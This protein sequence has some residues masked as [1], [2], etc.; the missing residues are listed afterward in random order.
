MLAYQERRILIVAPLGQDAQAVA[1]MLHGDGI[2]TEVCNHA[3]DCVERMEKGAG[4]LLLTEEALESL[5]TTE[6]LK[7]LGE[8]PPWSELPVIILTS[9]GESRLVGLLDLA[10]TAAR[11]VTLL[12]RPM[13]AATLLRSVQVALRSR[14]RQYQVRDLLLEQDRQHEKLRASEERFKLA[15]AAASA[16][17]WA[18][19]LRTGAAQWTPANYDLYGLSE[20]EVC[21][22]VE[23]WERNVHPEDLARVRQA[24][25]ETVE[26]VRPAYEVEYRVRHP[27]RGERWL[28]ALG[29]VERD[30]DGTPRRMAGIS[31]D[32]TARKEFQAELERLVRERTAKLQEVVGELEHFS[33]TITH[34]LKS[35]L[36][37]MRGFAELAGE[38]CGTS[39]AKPFLEKISRAAERMDA[40][41]RDALNYSRAV[42]QE[43]PLEDVDTGA[44]LRGILDSYPDF[45]PSKAHIRI[46]GPLPVVLGN[47]AGLTQ[48]FSNLLGNAVKFV[49][50]G[51]APE[52]RIWAETRNGWV[53]IWVADKGIGIA[54]SML[55]RVFDMFSRAS[56]A[57]E[58]T[59][60]GLA[61]VRK[62]VQRMGGRVGVD[63]QEGIGSRFWMEL[64]SGVS[65]AGQARGAV[66]GRE[67]TS[68]SVLYVE[69]EESDV[70]FMEMAFAK[71]GLK[72][73]LRVVRDG[74]AAIEYLSGAGRYGDRQRHPLPAVVLLDLN[75]P[76]VPGFEVLQWMR[77]HPEF[78]ST[79]VVIFSSSNREDD[80][81]KARELNANGFVVK[82]SSGLAFGRVVEDLKGKWL[83]QIGREGV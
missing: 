34:D 79:P 55:P 13:S 43:L 51:V 17:A 41:I 56:K 67:G 21:P 1:A 60:I 62:V 32:I 5:G 83:A 31:L 46:E 10:V 28:L 20:G 25:R 81:A 73:A 64:K 38:V 58:G 4:A 37:A 82:P 42:R 78:T 24:V 23:A 6:L 7:S 80:Q 9:G 76:Q 47:E 63:S 49:Q 57:Y 15:L 52:I 33:Y 2:P 14:W 59:G 39:E 75:L 48:C 45:Q 72:E 74:R 65:H 18:W 36:R 50:P 68:G 40:L 77:N 53:R 61:L 35:P 71:A 44:L 70:V 22:S 69:D 26:G 29:R 27:Q 66:S 11:S 54:E 3:A 19:D 12:E 8:Q 30:P 16:G